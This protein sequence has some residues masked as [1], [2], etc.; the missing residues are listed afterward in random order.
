M[1]G[2][3]LNMKKEEIDFIARQLSRM[4][5]VVRRLEEAEKKRDEKALKDTKQEILQIQDS[6]KRTL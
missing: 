5:D 3:I 4:K 6:I 1:N 2:V